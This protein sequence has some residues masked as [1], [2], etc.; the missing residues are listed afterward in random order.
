M[1]A[2]QADANKICD[3]RS[4]VLAAEAIKA[5]SASERTC[6]IPRPPWFMGK[7]ACNHCV[8]ERLVLVMRL[9]ADLKCPS[10]KSR[11]ALS[12][13][14]EQKTLNPGGTERNPQQ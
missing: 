8:S 4:E 9:S 13:E 7:L 3:W 2:V 10:N 12:T 14:G 5:G 6:R 1:S 11:A